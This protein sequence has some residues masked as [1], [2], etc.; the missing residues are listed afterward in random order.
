MRN[1]GS[2]MNRARPMSQM[3]LVSHCA[4]GWLVTE[5][6]VL[7]LCDVCDRK[8]AVAHYWHSYWPVEGFRSESPTVV[9]Y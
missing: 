9:T 5:A 2:R 3:A 7:F 6:L 4:G 8:R 1:N